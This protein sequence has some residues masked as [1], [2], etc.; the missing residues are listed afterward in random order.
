M[1]KKDQPVPQNVVKAA[2]NVCGVMV[3]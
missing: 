3:S 1:V 2:A